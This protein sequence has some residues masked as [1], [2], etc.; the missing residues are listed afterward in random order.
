[1]MWDRTPVV[2]GVLMLSLAAALALAV[3][4]RKLGP[5]TELPTALPAT[6]GVDDAGVVEPSTNAKVEGYLGVIL[7]RVS[8][9]IAA[10][11]E[12][13]LREV[14]VRLGDSVPAGGLLA[15][16]DA[17]PVRHD[18]ALA[19]VALKA[20]QVE[21]EQARVELAEARDKLARR[22]R[23]SEEALASAE[24]LATAR[25][26][27]QLADARVQAARAQLEEKRVRVEN[28]RQSNADAELRAPFEGTVAARFADP[29]ANVTSS[30]P[31][32]RLIS[33]GDMFVRFAVPEEVVT[34]MTI[35]ST[36]RIASVN[37]S[38]SVHGVIEK[39]AP[40]VDAAARMVIIEATLR[41]DEVPRGSLLAGE[42]ARVF[43][44]G[45][46]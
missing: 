9:D 45:R 1:M 23:L 29:G 22:Q 25:F 44:E 20:T 39:V 15:T 26:R 10:R 34:T 8:V 12:G 36:V 17:P 6:A 37:R 43:T 3:L 32:L 24:E 16:I 2:G 46:R 28:L 19:T 31:I 11:Y 41:L 21:L 30:T 33:D 42:M 14:H 27:E 5:P 7:P 4:D 13:R 18:L 35:G 38:V 40:E